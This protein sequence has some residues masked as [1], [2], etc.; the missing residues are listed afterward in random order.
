MA[1]KKEYS[2][3][4]WNDDFDPTVELGT[5]GRILRYF[6]G[7]PPLSQRE[8]FGIVM[9]G[10]LSLV[11]GGVIFPIL[12]RN[13]GLNPLS[14]KLACGVLVV[15]GILVLIKGI[16]QVKED[17]KKEFVPVEDEVFDGCLAYDLK[18]LKK[19]SKAELLKEIPAL[20]GGEDSI[21]GIEPQLLL[22][23]ETYVANVNLP[24]LYRVGKDGRVRGSN[25]QAMALY[26]GKETLYIYT[27]YYNMRD[28][29]IAFERKYECP[30]E[31][32]EKAELREVTR[33]LVTQD[34]K[35]EYEKKALAFVIIAREGSTKELELDI[36]DYGLTEQ[37]GGTL[38]TGP[39]EAMV[40]KINIL[41]TGL[42]D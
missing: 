25:Y 28:G 32:L 21:E 31:L 13:S 30:Y 33:T 2:V 35:K 42:T 40:K 6:G 14:I 10:V 24:F 4:T 17:S 7:Q 8:S 19:K 20:K 1:K 16:F 29:K 15:G 9:G 36:V 27:C 23:P 3:A 26:F 12:L 37:S 11:F 5:R 39:A 41:A 18:A 38:D 34:R 22:A